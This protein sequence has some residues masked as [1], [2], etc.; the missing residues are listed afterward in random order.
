MSFLP[1]VMEINLIFERLF[2]IENHDY[3][4]LE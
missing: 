4:T 2:T 1:L 3:G